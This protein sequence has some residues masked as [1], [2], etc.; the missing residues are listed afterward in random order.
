[1]SWTKGQR[2][3]TATEISSNDYDEG[4]SVYSSRPNDP[5]DATEDLPLNYI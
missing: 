5:A 3:E 4:R 2:L 1:M